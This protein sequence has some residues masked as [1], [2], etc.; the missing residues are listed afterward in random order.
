LSTATHSD[1]DTHETALGALPE[2]NVAGAE[3]LSDGA[4]WADAGAS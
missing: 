1:S 2:S 3:K 4:P